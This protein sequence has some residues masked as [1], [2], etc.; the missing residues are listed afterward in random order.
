MRVLSDSSERRQR[1]RMWGSSVDRGLRV[2]RVGSEGGGSEMR[3]LARLRVV[4]VSVGKRR[5]E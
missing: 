3:D 2:D 1:F 5:W 4:L